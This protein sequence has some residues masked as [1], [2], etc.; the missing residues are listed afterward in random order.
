VRRLR[1]KRRFT[2]ATGVALRSIRKCRV[3][4]VAVPTRNAASHSVAITVAARSARLRDSA[5]K[6]SAHRMYQGIT[7][8][9]DASPISAVHPAG[10]AQRRVRQ[11]IAAHAAT[12]ASAVASATRRTSVSAPPRPAA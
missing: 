12:A 11:A 1:S 4:A 6:G 9:T 8:L 5:A 2:C 3:T 7:Q 10:V